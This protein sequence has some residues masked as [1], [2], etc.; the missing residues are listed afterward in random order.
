MNRL[1][2]KCSPRIASVRGLAGGLRLFF[3][4]RWSNLPE[5]RPKRVLP[6]IEI[7][8]RNGIVQPILKV[9]VREN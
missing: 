1:H 6:E 2:L 4:V 3:N 7:L 5:L 8:R 9:S